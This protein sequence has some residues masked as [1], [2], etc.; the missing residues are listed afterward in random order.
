MTKFEIIL[1]AFAAG[2]ALGMPTE[3]MTY[4]QIKRKIWVCKRI[5]RS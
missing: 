2:D 5:N 4:R 3:F 1:E